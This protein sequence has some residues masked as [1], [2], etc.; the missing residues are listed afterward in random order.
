M[1][2]VRVGHAPGRAAPPVP[3]WDVPGSRLIPAAAAGSVRCSDNPWVTAPCGIT[4]RLAS[5]IR[6]RQPST[7]MLLTVARRA[8]DAL[9]RRREG[10]APTR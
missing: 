4:G 5:G 6:S 2:V 10:P 1:L 9:E 8:R 7:R 3:A